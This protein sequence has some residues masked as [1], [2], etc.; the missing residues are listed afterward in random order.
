[1]E[2]VILSAKIEKKRTALQIIPTIIIWILGV[3]LAYATYGDHGGLIHTK[4]IFGILIYFSDHGEG[5][6]EA[7]GVAGVLLIMAAIFVLPLIINA[8]GKSIAKRCQLNLTENQVFGELKTLFGSK[9]LQIPIEKLD[10]IVTE[11]SFLDKFRSGETL[12]VR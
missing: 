8:M 1:M 9:K 11:N 12:L 5:G 7:S 10:T 6:Y 2:D 3:L 4:V